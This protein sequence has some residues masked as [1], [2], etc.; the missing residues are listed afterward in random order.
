MKTKLLSLLF[1]LPILLISKTVSGQTVLAAGDIAVFQ[2]QADAPDDFAFVTFVD[3][4]A[5]TG[6][7]FTDCGSTTTGFIACTEGAFKY[8]VPNG[9]LSTGDIVRFNGN[10]DFVS[11]T[12]A[13]I[14]GSMG[15]AT[16]G[17]QV[18]AFQDATSATGG[19][20]A[21]ANPT[22]LFVIHNASTLFTGNPPDSNETNLPPGLSDVGLP[23]TALGVGAGPGVDVEWDNTVYN[24]T[25]DFSGFPDL[26]SSI[27]AAKI[28]FTDPANY[29][30]VDVLTDATYTTNV[31]AIPNALM[32]FTLST[33]SFLNSA[34]G[35]Y[36]NPA[37]N[38]LSISNSSNL[39]INEIQI[40]DITGKQVIKTSLINNTVDVS[41]LNSGMYLVHIKGDN[42]NIV[43]KLVK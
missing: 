23:R 41:S 11:Y 34:I 21:S 33:E 28:A 22:F 1:I 12:D 7:F 3:I 10:N 36:P 16:S 40:F 35:L 4:A 17:D 42:F 32:L 30:K 29:T 37:T 38:S 31:A 20:N 2:N 43:K 39:G 27:D 26:A 15:L 14:T 8:T 9:G 13:L 5:G 25:Y 6:I 18:I 24:G 19:T